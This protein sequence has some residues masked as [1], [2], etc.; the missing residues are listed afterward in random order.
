[1]SVVEPGLALIGGLLAWLAGALMP[2]LRAGVASEPAVLA[3]LAAAPVIL[4][5]AV[6]QRNARWL[7]LGVPFGIAAAWIVRP[8]LAEPRVFGLLGVLGLLSGI[9]LLHLS[10]RPA[11]HATQGGLSALRALPLALAL[12]GSIPLIRLALGGAERARLRG[13]HGADLDTVLVALGALVFALWAGGVWW[14]VRRTVL[15]ALLHPSEEREQLD[16]W[17]M[18]ARDPGRAAWVF[19]ASLA[20]A[21]ASGLALA[22]YLRQTR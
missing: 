19:L 4:G 17:A 1:M 20:V 9:G 22:L 10:T 15:P 21:I 16:A 7:L 18:A 2:A 13:A 8:E 6:G 12:A 14:L 11:R 3:A 5:L